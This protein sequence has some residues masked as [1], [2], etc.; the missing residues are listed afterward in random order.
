MARDS[1]ESIIA[2]LGIAPIVDSSVPLQKPESKL[3]EAQQVPE[4]KRSASPVDE[5][6]YSEALFASL[7]PGQTKKEIPK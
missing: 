3:T 5:P 1:T 7:Q 4:Q 6:D 2:K